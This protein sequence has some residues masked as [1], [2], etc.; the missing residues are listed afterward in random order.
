MRHI[1]TPTRSRPAVLN[2]TLAPPI[3]TFGIRRTPRAIADAAR[4]MIMGSY[5]AHRPAG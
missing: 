3:A 1:A 4:S 5:P 2:E